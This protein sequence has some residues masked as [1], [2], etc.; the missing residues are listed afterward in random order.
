MQATCAP[1]NPV[2]ARW[3]RLVYA[4]IKFSLDVVRGA[5]VRLLLLVIVAI[6][7]SVALEAWFWFSRPPIVRGLSGGFIISGT[8]NSKEVYRERVRATFA[9]PLTEVE[10]IGKLEQ[11]RFSIE[12]PTA[13]SRRYALFKEGSFPCLISWG[14]NWHSDERGD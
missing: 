12:G 11:Q 4:V 3:R 10:L 8:P 14:V 1:S 7:G 13:N 9:L 6:G 5:V 2:S